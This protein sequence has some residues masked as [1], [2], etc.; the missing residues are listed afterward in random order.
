MFRENCPQIA[1]TSRIHRSCRGKIPYQKSAR[2][3]P[4][5]IRQNHCLNLVFNIEFLMTLN[6][7]VVTLAKSTTFHDT[8]RKKDEC[9][10]KIAS[11]V[12]RPR[13]ITA[14]AEEKCPIKKVLG[15]FLETF[16]KIIV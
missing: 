7:N 3:F 1:P 9:F 6:K 8:R 10:E 5:D 15:I 2:H 13:E 4:R 14:P 11:M 12:W 16:V